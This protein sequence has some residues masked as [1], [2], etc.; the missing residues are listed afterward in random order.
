MMKKFFSIVLFALIIISGVWAV[1]ADP[2]PRTITQPN[3]K[4]LTFYIRGD[5][6]I[7]WCETLDGYTLLY[8]EDGYLEFACTDEN[9]KLQTSGILACNK[10]ER[11]E[12]EISFLK[13]TPKGLFF[14]DSQIAT[15]KQQFR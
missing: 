12:E 5:E 1:P 8:N 11:T 6:R 9:G 4:Q 14:N 13:E 3:G 15:M 2:H 7:H 10:E